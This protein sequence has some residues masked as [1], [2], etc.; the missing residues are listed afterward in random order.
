MH[1]TSIGTLL[2]MRSPNDTVEYVPSLFYES[3]YTLLN[4]LL[5][6]NFYK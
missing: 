5:S 3:T 1:L 2:S 6:N 4:L